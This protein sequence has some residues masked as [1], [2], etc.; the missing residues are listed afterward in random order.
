MTAT[1][2]AVRQKR[3]EYEAERHAQRMAWE[4]RFSEA[5]RSDVIDKNALGK[6]AQASGDMPAFC[7][8]LKQTILD[9]TNN[10]QITL[11][12]YPAPDIVLKWLSDIRHPEVWRGNVPYA[13][14]GHQPL[15][16]AIVDAHWDV[17]NEQIM[18]NIYQILN[19]FDDALRSAG[20]HESAAAL[21]DHMYDIAMELQNSDVIT[22]DFKIK[23]SGAG[24]KCN[25]MLGC[26]DEGNS[27]FG[28]LRLLQR[29]M[30][31]EE[32]ISEADYAIGN[33]ALSW[34]VRQQGYTMDDV[35]KGKPGFCASVQEEIAAISN[36]Q[37]ALAVCLRLHPDEIE[38]LAKNDGK[39]VRISKEAV[40]GCFAPWA[41]GG[42]LMNITLEKD[43]VLPK[44]MINSIQIEEANNREYTVNS[45]YGMVGSVWQTNLFQ[46]TDEAPF[47]LT[48]AVAAEDAAAI[49]R[50]IED[51]DNSPS[52]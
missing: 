1:Q 13:Q 4:K 20:L 41:G 37:N 48:E 21:Y 49:R 25:I 3:E 14:E 52:P 29:I 5:C 50:A 47:E 24:F 38:Q 16:D 10:G 15:T 45:V 42:S 44:S 40:I 23:H 2:K 22:S 17:V 35:I 33:N 28:N 34:L 51:A 39:N 19:E 12:I 11:D 18:D 26:K 30:S 9:V 7:A 32:D 43:I 46:L 27:D 36:V 31:G 8:M 6:A